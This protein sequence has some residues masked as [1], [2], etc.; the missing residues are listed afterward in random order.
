MRKSSV[1]RFVVEINNSGCMPLW[2]T[3]WERE[4]K[5]VRA[6]VKNNS[7][8]AKIQ[9]RGHREMT[10]IPSQKFTEILEKH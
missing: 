10:Q 6:K 9:T 2:E 1:N 7:V 5:T 8:E 4:M 3:P